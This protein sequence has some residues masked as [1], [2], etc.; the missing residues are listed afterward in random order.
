MASKSEEPS[1]GRASGK[2]EPPLELEAGDASKDYKRSVTRHEEEPTGSWLRGT[3]L[4]CTS[5][6]Q[7]TL[8][9]LPFGVAALGW[10]GGMIV[11]V[12][13]GLA[14]GYFN[15]LISGLYEH[16][17][18]RNTTYRDLAHHIMGQRHRWAY[19]FVLLLQFTVIIG[20]GV[21]NLILAG[22]CLQSIY[23]LYCGDSC[24]VKSYG[25]TFIAGLCL[26]IVAQ[27]PSMSRAEAVTLT[28]T[29]FL[30]T[31]SIIAVALAGAEGGGKGADYSIPGNTI[32]RVMNGFNAL[33]IVAFCYA[34]NIIPEIQ[35]TLQPDPATQSAVP[36]MKKAVLATT[37]LVSTIYI[38]VSVVGFWAYGNVVSG[39]LLD[40]MSHP[41]WL[42][43]IAYIMCV[44]N[45]LVGEQV[46]EMVMFASWEARVVRR[47]S[48][49]K[50]LGREVTDSTGRTV[51]APSR[52]TKLLIRVPYD[53]VIT[54][55]AAAFPFFSEIMGFVGA[56]GLTPL[57]FVM[58]VVLHLVARGGS[59][60]R[61][62]WWFQVALAT[63]FAACGALA[64]IGSVRSIVVAIQNHEFFS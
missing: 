5:T 45:L 53:L 9:G 57:C 2:A 51:R 33:G 35:S 41:A 11:L 60:S 16:G 43:T 30:V 55:V 31:Y 8:L 50:W 6:A 44:I 14:T 18:V 15:T 29:V 56:V 61:T 26:I 48:R 52:W 1:V 7:P 63:A 22:Q 64:T 40:M 3:W 36:P 47:F 42:L 25:W 39:F 62:L 27:L 21:A 19:H 4:L 17:G 34:N 37:S 59:M 28:T 46:V 23:S 38:I 49:F 32:N 54:V 24:T 13:S 58:P 20:V 10:V 12:V